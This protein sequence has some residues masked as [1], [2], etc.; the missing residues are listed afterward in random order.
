MSYLPNAGLRFAGR[1]DRL[2]F[3]PPN[4][5][6]F[7]GEVLRLDLYFLNCSIAGDLRNASTRIMITDVDRVHILS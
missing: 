6:H 3:F 7:E 1:N 5:Q 4:C 2:M